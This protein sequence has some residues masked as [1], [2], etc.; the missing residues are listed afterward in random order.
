MSEAKSAGWIKAFPVDIEKLYEKIDEPLPHSAK[1]WWWCWGGVVGLLFGVQVLTGLLLA[2]YYRAE[3]TTAYRSVQLIQEQVRFGGFVRGV[4]HWGA[5]FMILALFLHM[6]RVFVTGAFREHRWGAWMAGVALL[7]ITFGLAFT[8]Y[9]LISS[10]LS[11]W[12]VTVTSNILGSVPLVGGWLKQFFLAGDSINPATL[13]RMYALH[14]QILPA[15]LVGVV[16]AHLFFIRL[17]GLHR[18]G[19][20]AD[21]RAEEDLQSRR[22]AYHFYPD[23]LLSESAVFLFVLLVLM[24]FALAW[25]AM[26]GPE[27]DPSVTPEHIKPEWYF[28]PFFHLL[29]LVPG[30]VGVVIMMGLGAVLFFWPIVDQVLFSR[31]DRA[32]KGRVETGLVL[33]LAGIALYLYWAVLEA[34]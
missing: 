15:A 9:S 32:L 20:E 33:G 8:G 17:L 16:A 19:N 30:T 22:G 18:P 23:H 7:G 29:K 21:R 27:A 11:Y 12:G 3:P 26:I 13:S 6:A 10:Q 1:R 14:V 31:I 24:L 2:F 25:P 34:V 5:T 4:H 28:Y